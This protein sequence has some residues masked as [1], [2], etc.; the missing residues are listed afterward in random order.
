[1]KLALRRWQHW[2]LWRMRDFL[3]LD[4][5]RNEHVRVKMMYSL[6][7]SVFLV[8]TYFLTNR[9]LNATHTEFGKQFNVH[10]RKL[11]AKSIIQRLIAKFEKTGSMHDG[12]RGKVGPKQSACTPE[13]VEHAR[14]ILKKSPA[15]S[16]R[17]I[18]QEAGVSKSSLHRIVKEELHLYPYKIQML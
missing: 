16:V 3:M 12:K 2:I 13:T 1:M 9:N 14:Q 8:S 15:K 6:E 18:A 11:P 5:W 4:R 17:C 7:E 10:S